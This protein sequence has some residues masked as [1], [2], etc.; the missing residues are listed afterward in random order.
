MC[1]V[2]SAQLLRR[3]ASEEEDGKE[4]KARREEPETLTRPLETD[5]LSSCSR[6]RL[7][8]NVLSCSYSSVPRM[9]WLESFSASRCP[10]RRR[11]CCPVSRALSPRSSKYC[12][13]YPQGTSRNFVTNNQATSNML[14]PCLPTGTPPQRKQGVCSTLSLAGIVIRQIASRPASCLRFGPGS[15]NAPRPH[16]SSR[17][18]AAAP[19]SLGLANCWFPLV[20]A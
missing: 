20:R 4:T 10:R 14:L 3:V 8:S 12:M 13:V 11:P 18:S 17:T 9:P 6:A 16:P 7:A 1:E 5:S 15:A 19:D 2:V